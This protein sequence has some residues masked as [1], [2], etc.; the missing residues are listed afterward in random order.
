MRIG[1]DM[2]P[3]AKNRTGV[4]NF[5]FS[6]LEALLALPDAPEIRGLATGIRPPSLESLASKVACT[7][8]PV[9]ARAM[10]L[11]WNALRFPPVENLI[12]SV[13]VYHATNYFLP[14]SRRGRRVL[15]IYDLAFLVRPQWSSPRI[16]GPFSRTIR[17]FAHEADLLLA[18]SESTKRD[19]VNLLEVPEEKVRVT[20][21]APNASLRPVPR[22]E[23]QQRVADRF[24]IRDPFVLFAGTIEPRK[25]VLGLIRAFR[26]LAK[27]LPHRLVLAGSIGWNAES[28]LAALQDPALRDTVTRAGFVSFDELSAL[29]SAADVFVFPSFYEGFGLPVLEAM[30]CGCPVVTSNASSLPEV[31][32]DA[33]I[34]CDPADVT[35]LSDA[36]EHIVSDPDLRSRMIAAGHDRA[37][38]FT[39]RSCAEATLSAYREVAQ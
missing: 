32:G 2:G 31:G 6:L 26:A 13:D 20:Y 5:C 27:S 9:P 23:A 25:N 36:I 12:G 4:G 11:V 19:I 37:R 1:F 30:A 29:Y 22:D 3:I 34:Y 18:A 7:H 21:G 10:Y 14:P 38:R 17:R 8:L 28:T 24:G 39:W 15:S 16:A 33:A 35:G